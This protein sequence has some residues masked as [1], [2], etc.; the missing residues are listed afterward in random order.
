M[1]SRPRLPLVLLLTVVL[2][3]L[4]CKGEASR[5]HGSVTCLDCAAGHDLSGTYTVHLRRVE[6]VVAGWGLGVASPERP[7]CD[8]RTLSMIRCGRGGEMRCRQ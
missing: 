4:S 8:K 5:L 7:S 3:A 2:G 1:A 6:N